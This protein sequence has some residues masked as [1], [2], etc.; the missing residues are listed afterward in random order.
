MG[1]CGGEGRVDEVEVVGET[2][3]DRIVFYG[4]R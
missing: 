1:D 3:A 2:R 4:L